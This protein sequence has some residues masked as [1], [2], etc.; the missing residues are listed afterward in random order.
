M[1]T[2]SNHLSFLSVV[3]HFAGESLS[4]AE[5][6]QQLTTPDAQYRQRD[7]LLAF[8]NLYG[9]YTGAAQAAV[10]LKALDSFEIAPQLHCF[11]GDNATNNDNELIQG[12][13]EHDD[14]N[15]TSNNRI[16][17]A[18]HIINLV[19]KATLYGKGVS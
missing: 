4:I 16:R 10:I 9:D 7:I 17:C 14:I 5:F 19:V 13:N 12:L 15:L 1:W 6:W 2:S 11:V 18:E 3:G 8:Q